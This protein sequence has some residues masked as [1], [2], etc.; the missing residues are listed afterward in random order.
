MIFLQIECPN[1]IFWVEENYKFNK[2][3]P[4]TPSKRGG[5]NRI[6]LLP[7]GDERGRI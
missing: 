1:T 7:E 4:L 5:I 2:N 6:N 3:L